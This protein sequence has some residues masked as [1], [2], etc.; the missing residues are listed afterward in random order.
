MEGVIGGFLGGVL[1]LLLLFVGVVA[2]IMTN[3]EFRRAAGSPLC[4]PGSK[5]DCLRV[6]SLPQAWVMGF[7]LSQLAPAYYII[8]FILGILALAFNHGP[9][10]KLLA[11]LAWECAIIAPYMIYLMVRVAG[12]VCLY[13]LVMHAVSIIAALMTY[14][15]LLSGLGL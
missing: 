11:F 12:A 8:L 9:S 15:V 2:S 1:L 3:I 5:Y 4:K 13:C 10:L 7:H 6:Y 14:R